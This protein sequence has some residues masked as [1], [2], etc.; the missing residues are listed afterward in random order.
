VGKLAPTLGA[1]ERF[2]WHFGLLFDAATVKVERL[3]Q[4]AGFQR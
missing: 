2:S 4:I 3:E 1:P